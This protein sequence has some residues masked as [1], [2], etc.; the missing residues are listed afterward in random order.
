M[1]KRY[2]FDSLDNRDPIAIA[3]CCKW[4]GPLWR[5]YFRPI[6]RGLERIPEGPALYV[7]NH[8]GALSWDSLTFFGEVF[9]KR[10]I[11]DVPYALGHEITFWI[12]P[13]QQILV[14]LG[15]IRASHDN[16]R[17]A[18]ARGHKVLVY[19]GGD[20]DAMRAHRDRNK[21]IFGPR[22]GYVRLALT[23]GVPIVPVISVGAHSVFYVVDDGQWLAR[24]LRFDKLF[25]VKVCPITLSFPWG[26][27]VGPLVPYVPWPSRFFQEALPPI[28]FDRSGAEA[29]ADTAYVDHCHAIVLEA[30]QSAMD[31]LVA[32]RDVK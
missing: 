28:V 21:I 18:F 3:Q 23:E 17:R 24:M 22:R 10:G 9:D 8:N 31:R 15:V 5:A 2:D 7:G 11:A 4:W 27:T 30:M 12:P 32:E 14:P 19:P 6:V 13:A 20:L 25:R 26:L 29:A 16:A 1:M